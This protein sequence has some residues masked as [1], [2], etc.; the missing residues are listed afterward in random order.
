MRK[1]F[2]FFSYFFFLILGCTLQNP[3]DYRSYQGS[4]GYYPS[5]NPNQPG[6]PYTPAGNPGSNPANS[7][8]SN[9]ANPSQSTSPSFFG[10]APNPYDGSTVAPSAQDRNREFPYELIPNTL[11]TLTC[12]QTVIISQRN[13]SLN[14]GAYNDNDNGHGLQLSS[15][16]IETHDLKRRDQKKT[17]RLLETSPYKQ[18]QA[19]LSIQD[20]SDLRQFRGNGRG[21]VARAW[22]PPFHNPDTL[23]KLSK[24]ENVFQARRSRTSGGWSRWFEAN[25]NLTGSALHGFAPGLAPGNYGTHLLTLTYTL[26]RKSSLSKKE[27]QPYGRGYKLQF[28]SSGANYPTHVEEE[29]LS[30]RR[31]DGDWRCPKELRFPVHRSDQQNYT[32]TP[33]NK[34]YGKAGGRSD[35]FYRDEPIDLAKEGYCDTSKGSF[36]SL[37]DLHKWYFDVVFGTG[38]NNP[39]KMG[40]TVLFGEDDEKKT[41]DENCLVFKKNTAQC[42]LR[43]GHGYFRIE[44]DQDQMEDCARFSTDNESRYHICPAF[45]SFCY[46]TN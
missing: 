6:S 8:P 38:Q 14:L 9:N 5:Y 30:N 37:E 10:G 39:F 45:L 42:Y 34:L 16:F 7:S 36:N 17:R 19:R 27:N 20:E 41:T 35:T 18:A 28:D 3:N 33:F 12:P 26:N 15:A 40:K 21:Q 29:D 46:R 44:F 13:L 23:D 4:T 22:F 2:L 32:T 11:S 25:L 1:V 31:E 43:G 24:L